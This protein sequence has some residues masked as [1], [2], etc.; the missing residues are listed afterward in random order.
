MESKTSNWDK[1]FENELTQEVFDCE[2]GD[3]EINVQ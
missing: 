2:N 1:Q 3:G